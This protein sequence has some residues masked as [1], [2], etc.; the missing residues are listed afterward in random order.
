MDNVFELIEANDI[1][2][3]LLNMESGGYYNSTLKVIFINENLDED[4]QKEV[5]LHE[6]G[7]V[8]KHKD[9]SPLYKNF[10]YRSKME[11]EAT[12]Y[13]VKYLVDESDG[14]FNYSEVLEN[15]NLGL[16]WEGKI[17]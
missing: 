7:H 3:V 14:Q 10:Y 6:L 17:N 5:L 16:G 1:E 15:Y 4:S 8:L 9:F 13:M 11:N 12:K 2:V